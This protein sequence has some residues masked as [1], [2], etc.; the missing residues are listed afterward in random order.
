MYSWL[1]FLLIGISVGIAA[2]LVDF[3]VDYLMTWK[4][5]ISE[6]VF[7]MS[8]GLGW[9]TFLVFSLLFGAT[10]AIMTV[11]IGPGAAGG[12]TAELMGYLNGINY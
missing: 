5:K 4:W 10:A 11:F 1:A 12:G 8:L 7:K 9:I 6:I 2:F 3:L